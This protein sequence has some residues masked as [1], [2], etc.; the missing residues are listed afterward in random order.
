MSTSIID[1]LPASHEQQPVAP[2]TVRAVGERAVAHSTHETDTTALRDRFNRVG[3]SVRKQIPI[4]YNFLTLAKVPAKRAEMLWRQHQYVEAPLMELYEDY[5]ETDQPFGNFVSAVVGIDPSIEPTK[6]QRQSISVVTSSIQHSLAVRQLQALLDQHEAPYILPNE[7]DIKS[8]VDLYIK[9][10]PYRFKLSGGATGL[11]SAKVDG[12]YQKA[13]P[14]PYPDKLP[15]Q[16]QLPP[17]SSKVQLVLL[18]SLGIPT[19]KDAVL[20]TPTSPSP[21]TDIPKQNNP[22]QTQA[23]TEKLKSARQIA[24]EQRVAEIQAKKAAQRLAHKQRVEE[25]QVRKA[26]KQAQQEERLR[27]AEEKA[28]ESAKKAA[29]LRAERSKKTI[30][31]PEDIIAS[32][33]H[34]SVSP[35]YRA[36]DR[37]NDSLLGEQYALG[38]IGQEALQDLGVI[39]DSNRAQARDLILAQIQP[40]DP[41]HVEM[42][43]RLAATVC[44]QSTYDLTDMINALQNEISVSEL[45][46]FMTHIRSW[47]HPED[48]PALVDTD[49]KRLLTRMSGRSMELSVAKTA[50]LAGYEVVDADQLSKQ[51]GFDVDK[52]GIDLLINGVPFDIK[53][54]HRDAVL[55]TQKY[56]K[57]SKRFHT[58]KFVPPFTARDFDD[59]LVVTD[60]KAAEALEK[61]DF[62]QMIDEAVEQY[63]RMEQPDDLAEQDQTDTKAAELRAYERSRHQAAY[64]ELDKLALNATRHW[65]RK[66]K[67][68]AAKR[69][70]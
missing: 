17:Y 30:Y 34:H 60:S 64:D 51:L 40:D 69:W 26:A 53:S 37:V 1:H 13:L 59:R 19:G 10:K 45:R 67:K 48:T 14:T 44:L 55:H 20:S 49:T 9:G 68:A 29:R 25:A 57:D 22:Q 35:Y 27:I 32:L 43:K 42:L 28:A 62:L 58:V 4:H 18:N 54:N 3:A 21:Q 24:H 47:S 46:D 56:A 61:T 50:R 52:L 31:E 16:Y 39:N 23:S 70:G 66:V 33:P 15:D 63:L 65:G 38:I 36:R 11:I 6:H 7:D 12:T 8:G 2:T 5:S 41:E